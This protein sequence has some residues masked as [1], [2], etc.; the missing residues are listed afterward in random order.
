MATARKRT[1]PMPTAPEQADR[2]LT[3]E[4]MHELTIDTMAS[5]ALEGME[6]DRQTIEEINAFLRSG[7]SASEYL[8]K[9]KG[10]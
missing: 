2:V 7:L 5:W 8:R 10:D 6:P 4:Q 9:L 3:P 1:H